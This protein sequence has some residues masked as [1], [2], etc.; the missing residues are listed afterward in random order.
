MESLCGK[1]PVAT[2]RLQGKQEVKS[3]YYVEKTE[4]FVSKIKA[5]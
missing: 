3:S 5:E 2:L 1:K 4:D